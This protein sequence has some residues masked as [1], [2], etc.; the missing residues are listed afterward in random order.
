MASVT[1]NDSV[2]DDGPVMR[3]EFMY[4]NG[5]F[6]RYERE[7]LGFAHVETHE[8][9]AENA[10]ALVRVTCDDYD[11]SSYYSAGN[12]L[13]S[14]VSDG[15]GQKYTGTS[16]V[17]YAYNMTAGGPINNFSE[18]EDDDNCIVGWTPLKFSGHIAYEGSQTGLPMSQIRY[19]YLLSDTHGEVLTKTRSL[20][21]TLSEDGGDF[22]T[23]VSVSYATMPEGLYGY[24]SEVKVMDGGGKTLVKKAY[25]YGGPKS[26]HLV[27]MQQQV[28][29]NDDAVT[30]WSYDVYGNVS[31]V[32]LPANSKGERVSYTYEYERERNMYVK[33]IMDN[34]GLY[35][36]FRDFDYSY[37]MPLEREDCNG[38]TTKMEIDG[39]GRITKI[40]GPNE[41][42]DER[43]PFTLEYE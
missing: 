24:P 8:V 16:N 15:E 41:L 10:N 19:M 7:F 1:L 33:E 2:S 11:M 20:R 17:Y 31:G 36:R 5:Q 18:K 21:G 26:C 13:S 23:G 40:T 37:G 43:I 27:R 35:T 29:E 32:T 12:L 4:A 39:L 25:A 28:S 42:S 6:D 38:F 30:E 22:D 14:T 3:R 34:F 9:D